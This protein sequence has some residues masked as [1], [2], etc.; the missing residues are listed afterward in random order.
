VSAHL[1]DKP[2]P[3]FFASTDTRDLLRELPLAALYARTPSKT[4]IP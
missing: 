1:Q 4:P 3:D 2:L